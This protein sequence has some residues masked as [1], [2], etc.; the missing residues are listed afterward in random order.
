MMDE[1]EWNDAK[2]AVQSSNILSKEIFSHLTVAE[3]FSLIEKEREFLENACVSSVQVTREETKEERLEIFPMFPQDILE[4][5]LSFV[6]CGKALYKL[7]SNFK[8]FERVINSRALLVHCKFRTFVSRRKKLLGFPTSD[9]TSFSEWYEAN[10]YLE[11]FYRSG[12]KVINPDVNTKA[13]YNVCNLRFNKYDSRPLPTGEIESHYTTN[14]RNIVND[15]HAYIH[16]FMTHKA[17][18]AVID[19]LG[20]HLWKVQIRTALI[21]IISSYNFF[22]SRELTSFILTRFGR[23]RGYREELDMM[24]E[25]LEGENLTEYISSDCYSSSYDSSDED[26]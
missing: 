14:V 17:Y 20:D 2:V 24:R 15:S 22:E 26:Y 23:D 1:S 13:I 7:A 5:I 6:D 12:E 16:F 25:I 21:I 19:M 18:F 10:F 3:I 4:C 8:R 11:H 9:A